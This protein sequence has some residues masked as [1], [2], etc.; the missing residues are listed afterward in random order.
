MLT[1]R[2]YN[3]SFARLLFTSTFTSAALHPHSSSSLKFSA[4]RSH[5]PSSQAVGIAGRRWKSSTRNQKN[6]DIKCRYPGCDEAFD[7]EAVL[8][9]HVKS[10]IVLK[11]MCN[12]CGYT[13]TTRGGNA[14]G[15]RS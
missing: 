14:S 7:T 6:N 13:P 8:E 5:F 3:C 10:H 4:V 15:S 1:R 9:E 11:V 2:L 12:Y